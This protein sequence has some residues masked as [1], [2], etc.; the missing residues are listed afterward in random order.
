M[1]LSFSHLFPNILKIV[2]RLSK[3]LENIRIINCK[4]VRNINLLF[5]YSTSLICP[6]FCFISVTSCSRCAAIPLAN[7][8]PIQFKIVF[9]T[10]FR[11]S[12]LLKNNKNKK[13]KLLKYILPNLVI[14]PYFLT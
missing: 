11:S 6:T 13:N 3:L 1:R 9:T 2:Q 7:S 4:F 14:I 8:G 5:S 12:E 10:F